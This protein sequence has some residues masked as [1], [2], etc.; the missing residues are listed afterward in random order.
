MNS[1]LLIARGDI[2]SVVRRWWYSGLVAIGLL[3]MVVAVV[4]AWGKEGRPQADA[5]RADVAS[6]Y[7][8]AGLALALTVGATTFWPA[9]QSG[10]LGLLTASGA[11]RIEIALGRVLGRVVA[12]LAAFAL[13]IIG[14][15]V[16][17]IVL[18][19]GLDGPLTVHGLT[20]TV[21]VLFAMLAAAA[22]ST[23]M[24]PVVAGFVGMS[25]YIV[26]QAVVNLEAAADLGRL[27]SATGTVHIAYDILPRSILSPMIVDMHNRGTGGPAS[28]QLEINDIPVTVFAS[29]WGSVV[30]TLL[31]CAVMVGLC[32]LGTRRRTFN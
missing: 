7:L 8:L 17:S 2:T 10:H 12:L 11:R 1:V 32:N 28:P 27:G 30:W 14:S 16:A 20:M 26:I 25:A 22:M 15:Q 4:G 24:G 19:R 5:F 23:V 31:W 13:W 21:T 6:V 3:G 29:G 9:I 18:D